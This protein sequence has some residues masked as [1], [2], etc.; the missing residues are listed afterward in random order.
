MA[1]DEYLTFL[2]GEYKQG[3]QLHAYQKVLTRSEVKKVEATEKKLR[4]M[5]ERYRRGS[6]WGAESG[7]AMV[8]LNSV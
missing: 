8:T 3:S 4:H 6:G 7:C 2:A 5:P 1:S